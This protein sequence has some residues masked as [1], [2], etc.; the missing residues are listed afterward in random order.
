MAATGIK[1]GNINYNVDIDESVRGSGVKQ[2]RSTLINNN[3]KYNVTK[4]SASENAGQHISSVNAID[5]DWKS[6]FRQEFAKAA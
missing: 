6:T 5:I 4:K 2:T 1:I 3:G